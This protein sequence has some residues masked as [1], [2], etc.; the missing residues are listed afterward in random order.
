MVT[1]WQSIYLKEPLS[2]KVWTVTLQTLKTLEIEAQGKLILSVPY[3][4]F[5]LFIIYFFS[6]YVMVFSLEQE[7]DSS[8][9][10]TIHISNMK[11]KPLM[12]MK[13]SE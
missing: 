1:H 2:A 8:N 12:D 4:S 5:L 6:G 7:S 10:E 11:M 3:F 9:V 13:T